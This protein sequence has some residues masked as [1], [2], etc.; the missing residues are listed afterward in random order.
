VR[1]NLRYFLDRPYEYYL[2]LSGDQLYRMDYADLLQAHLHAGADVTLGTTRSTGR[3]LRAFGILYSDA[4]RHIF[5]FEEKPKDPKL[6]DEPRIPANLL[7]ELGL[8][9]DAELYQGSMGIY[10]F[11]RQVL[12]DA[13]ANNHDD[14]GKHVI[15]ASLQKYRVFAYIFQGCW[16]DIGTVRAFFEA[17]LALTDP[18]PAFDFFD[19]INRIYTQQR[20]LPASKVSRTQVQ[21][22]IIADGSIITDAHIDRAV[23]GIRSVIGSGTTIRNSVLMG[24]TFTRPK[25]GRRSRAFHH[26][27]SD[28]AATLRA[29]LSTKTLVL[30][31]ES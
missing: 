7:K 9:A 27:G 8:P 25:P 11:N 17:N 19:Q 23:I 2:I 5:R 3:R 10:V 4:K 18:V 30:G 20:H 21:R 14:F 6:L 22:A 26:L 29:P 28:A 24:Q 13:L 15:P 1:Q 31:K 12:I 16:E